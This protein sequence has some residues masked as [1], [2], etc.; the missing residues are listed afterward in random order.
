MFFHARDIDFC[1]KSAEYN[2]YGRAGVHKCGRSAQPYTRID[3]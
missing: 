3:R 1:S 2:D